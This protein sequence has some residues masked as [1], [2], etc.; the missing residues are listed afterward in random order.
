LLSRAAS[1]AGA[2]PR[3]SIENPYLIIAFFF[4]VFVMGAIAVGFALPR[5]FAPYVQ[6]PMVGVVTMM[7][8]LS[9]QEM[10][11]YVSKPIEEQ[12]VNVKDLHYV[13]STSQEGFSL[14]TL[15]FNYG[16]DMTKALFDAQALMNVIQAN[17]PGTGANLKPSWVV[18]IDPLNLPILSLALT[19]DQAQGWTPQRLREFADNEVINRL[20]RVQKVYSVVPFGGYRRQLQV[21]VDRDQ[22][23]AYRL[24]ILDVRNAID[25]FNVSRPAGTLTFGADE[26]IVRVDTR[27]TSAEDVLNYP[28]VSVTSGGAVAAPPPAGAGGG[29]GGGGMGGM[30]AG[31]DETGNP[32]GGGL[33]RGAAGSARSPRTVYLRDVARVA[34]TH[35]ERRSGYHFL[36]HEPGRD[37]A[38]APAIEVSIIQD[39]GSSSAQVVPAVMQ[40]VRQMER[41]FPGI[42]FETAYD[43]ARF[44]DVLFNNIWDELLLAILMTGVALLLFLGDWR[45]ALVA[46]VSL[47]ASLL[48]AILFMVPM[49]MSFNSGTLIGLL[50]SIGRLVDDSIVNVHSVERHLRMGK[51]VKTATIDGI[52]EIRLAV[53]AGTFTTL[54]GL[55][56]LLFC[57]GIVEIM[58]RE[59][60][61]P[62]IFCQLTSMIVGFTLTTLLCASLLRREEDRAADR[63]HPV[64]RLLFFLIDPFQRFLE[65]MERGYE[66]A[67]R[68]TLR[69]RLLVGS[70]ILAIIIGGFTFYPLIGSEMMPLADVGQASG[71]LEMAPGT[72]FEETERAVGEIERIMLQYPELEKGSIEIGAETMFES[73]S[74]FYTGYAMPQANGAAFM[75]T[76]SDKDD[77]KRTIFQMMDAIHKEAFAKIP[78]IR[79]FQ[80]KEMGSD[81]MATAAAPV[82]LIAYGPDLKV[83]DLVGRQLEDVAKKTPGVYQPATT[84]TL[85][86]PEYEIRVD[87]TRA[88][89][90]GLSPES[91]SQQA[92]YS[93]RGGLTNEFYRLPN[94]RQNT[95]LVRYDDEDR[96]NAGDLESLYLTT[97]DGRQVP[98][99][100][101]ATVER[102]SAPTVI[103]HDGLRRV[104]GL[105]AYYRIGDLPSMDVAMNL[106]SNAY[107]G[108]REAG[109]QPINFPPGYGLEMR[110]DMTQMMDSFRRLFVGLGLSL[111]MM[112]LILVAQF[113]GFIQPF[114]MIASLPDQLA[115]IFFL[116]FVTGQAFSSVSIMALIVVAGM[117]ITTAI[118]ML[119]L[120]VQYRDQGV[121]RDE[122]VAIACPARLRPIIMSATITAI[123]II[124]AAFFPKTGQDA[125]SS[126]AVVT[127][128]GLLTGTFLS[129]FDVPIM[130]T[131]TDDLVRWFNKIF[132]NRDWSWP[133]QTPDVP[134]DHSQDGVTHPPAGAGT[135]TGE[136]P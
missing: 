98:L 45:S 103:E 104:V 57:G 111:I 16:V 54:V 128:G 78:G 60:V 46:L 26:G 63:R 3:W 70:F 2:L 119:D 52:G 62:V 73:W 8:G 132:L 51:D 42:Q 31:A 9:A 96:R 66:R 135:L 107:G 110:G 114:Q 79:R 48:M 121:P 7:P 108:N 124:P 12:M 35:W 91:I 71:L 40:A 123:A 4:A 65:R 68:W 82:H 113:R 11:L 118:L 106:V 36:K 81:V 101:V 90:M 23:A 116:L 129:L 93:L 50:I 95:I 120:I 105:T 122:A 77:R 100:T 53:L 34:D 115:G 10:E 127:I 89:E 94:L 15:E 136:T 84:W 76:F 87:P 112:Y 134:E 17:L 61:W 28:L 64:G 97:P 126:L 22:L 75:L 80:I 117:D 55:S 33:G 1:A 88:Q 5:R 30:G 47:P 24:S 37:G 41:D 74:P 20:K 69:R 39:P 72:S 67:V 99:S 86:L 59:L 92:Y 14:V 109:I 32:G 131:F 85:G 43:N 44:T 6:S 83:L 13:R 125:Y 38:V 133:V 49:G 18:P 25:R 29:M 102:R 56:P 58:F 130:H 19:G 21:V 27:A